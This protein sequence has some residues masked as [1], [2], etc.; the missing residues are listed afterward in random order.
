MPW[1]WGPIDVRAKDAEPTDGI[2]SAT[3]IDRTLGSAQCYELVLIRSSLSERPATTVRPVSGSHSLAGLI[4]PR[5][6][7]TP[8]DNS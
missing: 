3:R 7:R 2:D 1:I 6:Q 4:Q 5:T 8:H